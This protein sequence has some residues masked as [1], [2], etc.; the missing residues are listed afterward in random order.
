MGKLLFILVLVMFFH[1]S[2]R[3]QILIGGKEGNTIYSSAKNHVQYIGDYD[4]K[5]L[6]VRIEGYDEK[7]DF[8]NCGFKIYYLRFDTSRLELVNKQGVVVFDTILIKNENEVK[9]F[10]QVGDKLLAGGS[11]QKKELR[12]LDKVKAKYECP[13]LEPQ[14]YGFFFLIVNDKEEYIAYKINGAEIPRGYIDEI[15]QMPDPT[16]IYIEQINWGPF[17][18][19]SETINSIVIEIR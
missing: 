15:M 3:S 2:G 5:E 8:E 9:G 19:C 4:C 14:V 17:I 18:R 1:V 11:I 7:I 6:L 12:L 10:L 13:W 16:K